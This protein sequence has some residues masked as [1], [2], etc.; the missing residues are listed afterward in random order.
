VGNGIGRC[1]QIA[2][3]TRLATLVSVCIPT[4]GNE[5]S[6]DR[7]NRDGVYRCP[8]YGRGACVKTDVVPWVFGSGG[9]TQENLSLRPLYRC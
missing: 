1:R 2:I 4:R 7:T 8:N 3:L 9:V 6:T 5:I